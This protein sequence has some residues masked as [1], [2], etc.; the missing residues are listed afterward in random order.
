MF[1][2]R[3]A[4]YNSLK[5]SNICLQNSQTILK[6]YFW[7]TASKFNEKHEPTNSNLEAK[8]NDGTLE[9]NSANNE[10]TF[11]KLQAEDETSKSP[12]NQIADAE[13]QLILDE[14]L[15]FSEKDSTELEKQSNGL[16]SKDSFRSINNELYNVL[17][18]K[19]SQSNLLES[20]DS[21]FADKKSNLVIL[22]AQTAGV[23]KRIPQNFQKYQSKNETLFGRKPSLKLANNKNKKALKALKVSNDLASELL[24]SR[25]TSQQEAFDEINSVDILLDDIVNETNDDLLVFLKK[26][27]EEHVFNS[28]NELK[29]PSSMISYAEYKRLFETVMTSYK[30]ANLIE[31][32]KSHFKSDKL[33]TSKVKKYYVNMILKD[34]WCL[35][36]TSKKNLTKIKTKVFNSDKKI[37]FFLFNKNSKI[38][39][40]IRS[41]YVDLAPRGT[42]KFI[43]KGTES[44]LQWFEATFNYFL[45]GLSKEY[46]DFTEINKFLQKSVCFSKIQDQDNV[47]FEKVGENEYILNS[48]LNVKLQ[49]VKR[50]I[51]WDMNYNS[52]EKNTIG[53]FS[54]NLTYYSYNNSKSVPW[55]FRYDSWGRLRQAQVSEKHLSDG[56]NE[57][58][59]S[60][61]SDSDIDRLFDTLNAKKKDS[62]ISATFGEFLVNS[63]VKSYL[64][65]E[66]GIDKFLNETKLIEKPFTFQTTLPNL[67]EQTIKNPLFYENKELS[68]VDNAVLDN[69]TYLAQIRLVPNPYIRKSSKISTTDMSN[70][71]KYPTIEMWMEIDQRNEIQYDTLSVLAVSEEYNH[72]L[73]LSDKSSDLKFSNTITDTIYKLPVDE[74]DSSKQEDVGSFDW[75]EKKNDTVPLQFAEQPDIYRFLKESKLFFGSDKGVHIS[76]EVTI[77]IKDPEGNVV[78]I[79]YIY[80]NSNYKRQL[81]FAY[82]DGYL[83]Q[84]SNIQGGILGGERIEVSLIN[85]QKENDDSTDD[86]GGQVCETAEISLEKKKEKFRSFFRKA[87]KFVDGISAS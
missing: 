78:P 29:P 63:N 13:H 79:N 22:N 24:I 50:L 45:Q 35:K 64:N 70:L 83:L 44:R 16:K 23:I 10:T 26:E 68:E 66:N 4:V 15:S 77:N 39:N 30:R 34:I 1:V 8:F 56:E 20:I 76:K 33:P 37:N 81:D 61:F 7:K 84:F 43:A 21:K 6:R 51:V 32:C 46:I 17:S 19:E 67:K 86:A 53:E 18:N 41:N 75:L 47:Y 71:H 54:D 74:K 38:L 57:L 28:I 31:Y 60:Q 52:K 72:Y 59:Q 49:K 3:G 5:R 9:E 85:Y 27:N 73:N 80:V 11:E 55:I 62:L 14:I 82:E 40:K 87:L 48:S 65:Q 12:N 36:S 69:H 2:T 25:D 58:K 42:D